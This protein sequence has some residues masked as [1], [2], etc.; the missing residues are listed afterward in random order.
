MKKYIVTLSILMATL[1]LWTNQAVAGSN[2]QIIYGG[3]MNCGSAKLLIEKKILQP[4]T[5][6]T[7]VANLH[8]QDAHYQPNSPIFFKISIKNS[9]NERLSNI[10]VT[11]IFDSSRQFVDFANGPGNFDNKNKT[12]TYTI[13]ALLPNEEKTVVLAGKT[14]ASKNFPAN[15]Q[16][17]CT[18]N[19]TQASTPNDTPTEATTEFC[20]DTNEK[21]NTQTKGGIPIQNQI[22]PVYS[23]SPMQKNPNTG[24]E[25]L[26]LIGL[27]PTGIFGYWLRKKAKISNLF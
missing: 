4:G 17:V 21:M 6:N 24:P 14:V 11:S 18:T 15:Q 25:M 5:A 12:L 10:T 1:F 19:S 9:T 27:L 22:L 7:Y 2:C 26:P 20:I 16:V 8:T 23:P 13:D 3:G